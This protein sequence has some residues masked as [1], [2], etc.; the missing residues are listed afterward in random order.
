MGLRPSPCGLTALAL[1]APA[2][3]VAVPHRVAALCA[4]HGALPPTNL[5]GAGAPSGPWG[6]QRLA[7]PPGPSARPRGGGAGRPTPG[8]AGPRSIRGF[9][10]TDAGR[11][12]PREEARPRSQQ[13]CR[14]SFLGGF[15]G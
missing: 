13:T 7:A 5:P 9:G 6:A 12:V 15:S 14:P 4:A 8:C 3:V 11:M 10:M 2:P 1:L